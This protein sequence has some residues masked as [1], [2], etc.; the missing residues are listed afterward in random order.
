MAD[1]FAGEIRIGGTIPADLLE[2]FLGEVESTARW[3]ATTRVHT[4][5]PRPPWNCASP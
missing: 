2:E 1:Y 3:W 4:L 5:M